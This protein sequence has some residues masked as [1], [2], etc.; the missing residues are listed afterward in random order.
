MDASALERGEGH[1]MKSNRIKDDHDDDYFRGMGAVNL[2]LFILARV[3]WETFVY[4]LGGFCI[5]TSNIYPTHFIHTT[6]SRFDS[7][8]VCMTL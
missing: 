5:E 8:S 3:W 1:Q 6:T 7:L 2:S 4:G